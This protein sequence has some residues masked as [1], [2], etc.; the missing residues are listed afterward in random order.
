M[1]NTENPSLI[2]NSTTYQMLKLIVFQ[3]LCPLMKRGSQRGYFKSSAIWSICLHYIILL[4]INPDLQTL[5]QNCTEN[6]HD[7]EVTSLQWARQHFQKPS[8]VCKEQTR[9]IFSG[10]V[11]V[12]KQEE[13]HFQHY[14]NYLF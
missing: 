1:Q 14:D 2:E 3:N 5:R 7:S 8:L 12:I 9:N 6:R 4:E 13:F 11:L 10:P